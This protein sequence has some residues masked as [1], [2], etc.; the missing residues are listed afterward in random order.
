MERGGVV[1]NIMQYR[2]CIEKSIITSLKIGLVLICLQDLDLFKFG[3]R[4]P[5]GLRPY[6]LQIMQVI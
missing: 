1:G 4:D 6:K 2:V 3:S 5:K